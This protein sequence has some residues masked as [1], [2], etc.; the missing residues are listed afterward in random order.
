MDLPWFIDFSLKRDQ[1]QLDNLFQI[2]FTSTNIVRMQ[3]TVLPHAKHLD[4][5]LP[6]QFVVA[7][8][9]PKWSWQTSRFCS[10][11]S[12][13]PF[14]HC[15]SWKFY[16]SLLCLEGLHVELLFCARLQTQIF[17]RWRR[18][19]V[20]VLCVRALCWLAFLLISRAIG[21][22]ANC[23]HLG[24]CNDTFSW[25]WRDG[26]PILVLTSGNIMQAT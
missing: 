23:S 12:R 25:G 1:I 18:S 5:I 10:E 9:Q 22:C 21:G 3:G 19:L 16:N 24:R 20:S 6:S 13:A 2:Q 7:S 4:F 14:S 26:V 17:W 8:C 15:S 11:T